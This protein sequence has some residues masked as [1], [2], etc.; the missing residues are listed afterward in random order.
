M[1]LI[2]PPVLVEHF[3]LKKVKK[4][5]D[6]LHFYFEEKTLPLVEFS[7]DTFVSKGFS[8]EVIIDDFSVNG[9]SVCLHIA[10]LQWINQKSGSIVKRNWEKVASKVGYTD[11]FVSFS[12][13][14]NLF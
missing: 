5:N 11:D 12:R 7:H 13:E 2:F 9:R 1:K 10:Q 8:S 14:I 6:A 3:N 4:R